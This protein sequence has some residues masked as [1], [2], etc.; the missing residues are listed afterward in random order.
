[1]SKKKL[2]NIVS[3]IDAAL[4]VIYMVPM[5]IFGRESILAAFFPF[6]VSLTFIFRS[7]PLAINRDIEVMGASE[8]KIITVLTSIAFALVLVPAIV[9]LCSGMEAIKKL[10]VEENFWALYP[11]IVLFVF[12][13]IN[14]AVMSVYKRRRKNEG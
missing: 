4:L 13:M 6:F 9:F 5:Y 7:F 2:R 1:M 8:K 14:L 10:T 12:E 11:Y 3:W